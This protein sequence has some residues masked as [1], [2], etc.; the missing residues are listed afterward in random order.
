MSIETIEEFLDYYVQPYYHVGAE[1]RLQILRQEWE[2]EAVEDRYSVVETE[3]RWCQKNEV[4]GVTEEQKHWF[5]EGLIQALLLMRTDTNGRINWEHV[6]KEYLQ[7]EKD[8][9]EHSRY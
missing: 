4:D 8:K 1:E 7:Q 5:I 6:K 9:D 3:L 2:R